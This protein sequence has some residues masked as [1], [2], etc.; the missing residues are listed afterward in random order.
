MGIDIPALPVRDCKTSPVTPAPTQ[1]RTV[2][3]YMLIVFSKDYT[4]LISYCCVLLSLNLRHHLGHLTHHQGRRVSRECPGSTPSSPSADPLFTGL[5]SAPG[6]A[7]V[8]STPK[9]NPEVCSARY[10]NL[11]SR[12]QD[13]LISVPALSGSKYKC[14]CINRIKSKSACKKTV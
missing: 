3:L 9:N 10:I 7:A 1:V 4:S 11:A 13:G 12:S 8:T 6:F 2:N 14:V 5:R